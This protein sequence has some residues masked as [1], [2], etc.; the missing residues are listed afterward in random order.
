M[1]S[2]R[3]HSRCLNA[4]LNVAPTRLTTR[5]LLRGYV[6]AGQC[7]TSKPHGAYVTTDRSSII[8]YGH[9]K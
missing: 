7:A 5:G 2:M 3:L 4:L 1:R 9:S 8:G 6:E